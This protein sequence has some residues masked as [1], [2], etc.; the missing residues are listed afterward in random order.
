MMEAYNFFFF[1]LMG[2]YKRLPWVLEEALDFE[3]L[4]RLS[5]TV[6]PFKVELAAFCTVI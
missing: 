4:L 6:E 1:F 3:M 2:S 5:K